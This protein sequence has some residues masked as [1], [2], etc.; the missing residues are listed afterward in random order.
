MAQETATPE[1][2]SER[3]VMASIDSG[4]NGERLI[5]AELCQEDAY[6]AMSTEATVDVDDWR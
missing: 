1:T 5:I 3:E 4:A 6:L 2:V